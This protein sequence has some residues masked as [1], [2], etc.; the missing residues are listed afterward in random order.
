MS[1]TLEVV[2]E[3]CRVESEQSYRIALNVIDRLVE[4]LYHSEREVSRGCAEIEQLSLADASLSGIAEDLKEQLVAMQHEL[5]D[6]VDFT[7]ADLRI[8][9]QHDRSFNIT[10]FGRTMAGKSTLMSIL[11]RGNDEAIGKGAQRTT[12]DIREYEWNGMKITD[13]PGIEA[14]EGEEDDRMA[15]IGAK[16]ADLIIFMISSGQPESSEADW[17]VRLKKEDKAIVCLCNYKKNLGSRAGLRL[18]LRDAEGFKEKMNLDGL[19]EQFNEFLRRELPG[20]NI[21]IHVAMLLAE[22]LAEK[23]EYADVSGQLHDISRFDD[24]KKALISLISRRGIFFRRKSYLAIIDSPVYSH[25]LRLHQFANNTYS[26]LVSVGM[27]EREFLKWREHFNRTEREM[28]QTRVHTIFNEVRV[29]VADFVEAN[30]ER[31]DIM[32]RWVYYLKKFSLDERLNKALRESF[33]ACQRKINEIFGD[34]ARDFEFISGMSSYNGIGPSGVIT[35]W[36]KLHEWGS[37]IAGIGAAMGFLL[38]NS[39]P[40]GWIFTGI[41]MAFGLFSWL[42]TSKTD[43]LRKARKEMYESIMNALRE[44][45]EKATKAILNRFDNMIAGSMQQ[46]ALARLGL[47]RSTLETVLAVERRCTLEYCGLHT[48]ISRALVDN[49]LDYEREEHPDRPS[50]SVLKAARIPGKAIVLVTEEEVSEPT[51][52]FIS[53]WMGGS[54]EVFS[55]RPD[56]SLET[57]ASKFLPGVKLR[58]RTDADGTEIIIAPKLQYTQRQTDALDL[59]QQ[60]LNQPIIFSNI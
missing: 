32:R 19:K 37:A 53:E 26:G 41:G 33:D 2:L 18:A 51:C 52:R 20:E 59:M 50:T 48:E 34:L 46:T 35:D 42:S 28:L 14:F 43:K 11:T 12:R 25:Y 7:L 8:K 10:L 21:E 3:A 60:L 54:E 9:R 38:L 30:V 29:S 24:F 45:E 47:I 5:R 15:E 49:V 27:K 23:P 22:K 40:V 1:E 13:V 4:S 58:T 16:N 6:D 36:K 44:S 17:L 55:L 57:L 31:R 56:L 39:N